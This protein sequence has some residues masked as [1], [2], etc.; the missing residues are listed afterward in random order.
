MI[1][2]ILKTVAIIVIATYT[3]RGI[4]SMSRKVIATADKAAAQSK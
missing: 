1:G 2:Q 4:D 3:V